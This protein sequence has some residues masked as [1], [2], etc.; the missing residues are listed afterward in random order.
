M[1]SIHSSPAGHVRQT[2]RWSTGTVSNG[3]G[4]HTYRLSADGWEVVVAIL[5]VDDDGG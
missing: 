2:Y 4:R 3:G 5:D 1:L